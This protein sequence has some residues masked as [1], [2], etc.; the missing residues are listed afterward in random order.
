MAWQLFPY[1][2]SLTI[3]ALTDLVIYC[4]AVNITNSWFLTIIDIF[5]TA[6]V[7][8]ARLLKKGS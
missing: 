7:I 4:S 8:S 5:F 3:I 2:W 6:D 1:R